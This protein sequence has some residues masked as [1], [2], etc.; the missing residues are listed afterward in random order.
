[1]FYPIK[2]ISK[3]FLVIFL[4]SAFMPAQA[5]ISTLSEAIN[6]AGK[7][8]MLSQRMVKDYCLV[9]MGVVADS[10]QKELY[11]SMELFNSQLNELKAF[12]MTKRIKDKL[13][14]VDTYWAEFK[15]V[16]EGPVTKEKAQALQELS[17][18]LLRSSNKVVLALT[19]FVG[20][21]GSKIINISGRQRMLSQR[22]AKFYML[23]A[24]GLG[25]SEVNEGIDRAMVEFKGALLMLNQSKLNTAETKDILIK[26]NRSFKELSRVSSKQS[27]KK[28]A[29]KVILLTEKM[30]IDMNTA[31][32]LYQKATENI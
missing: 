32:S 16:S 1:M 20:S 29:A 11:K 24:W 2:I 3:L 28:T 13:K 25:N 14:R 5:E 8:R 27:N 12:A 17:E 26:V 31:T 7:Q 30:L 10:S 4:C 22:V 21:S 18:D 9:G 19:D 15:A 23:D 6:K